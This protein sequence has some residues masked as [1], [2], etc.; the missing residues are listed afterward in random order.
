M[1]CPSGSPSQWATLARDVVSNAALDAP[2]LW[3]RSVAAGR[4]LYALPQSPHPSSLHVFT[5]RYA[6]R[7]FAP[8]RATPQSRRRQHR[9]LTPTPPRAQHLLPPARVA[10][11][12][13]A[14]SGGPYSPGDLPLNIRNTR[15]HTATRC[16]A[17][18]GTHTFYRVLLLSLPSCRFPP[19]ERVVY[20]ACV[21]LV[22]L[23]TDDLNGR[24]VDNVATRHL[25]TAPDACTILCVTADLHHLL[26]KR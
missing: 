10:P 13:H 15:T 9:S 7:L 23:F 2:D 19:N 5:A 24:T 16:G 3:R 12:H 4:A 25:R 1:G 6:A 11:A 14:H 26:L 21:S 8:Q 20:H 18:A 17:T 22:H